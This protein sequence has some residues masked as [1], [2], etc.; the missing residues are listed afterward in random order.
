MAAL[1]LA[2]PLL[3]ALQSPWH[4]RLGDSPGDLLGQSLAALGDLD[5]DGLADF[6]AGLPGDNPAGPD[7]GAAKVLS[8]A[9]GHELL[10]LVGRARGERFGTSV[11]LAGD[12]DCD[13]LPD[14]FVG[15]PGASPGGLRGAGSAQL[16]SGRNAEVIYSFFGTEQDGELGSAVVSAGDMDGDGLPEIAIGSPGTRHG[17]G[18]VHVHSGADASILYTFHGDLPYDRFGA[19]LAGASDVDGDGVSDLAV[20]AHQPAGRAPGYARVLSGADASILYTFGGEEPG[21]GFG[22]AVALVGDLDGDGCAEVLVGAPFSDEMGAMAG[23]ARLFSGK[24]GEPLCAFLGDRPADCLGIAVA[25]VGDVDGDGVPD[26]AAGAHQ[27]RTP[28]PG[29]LRLW[30]GATRAELATL[31]G[32]APGHEFGVAAAGLGDLDGDGRG[33]IAVG[34]WADGTKG[35]WTG[36]VA[37][38]SSAALLAR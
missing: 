31:V 36:S 20:G 10:N 25:G 24:S 4:V 14:V 1:L 3:F 22:L 7:S 29:Y 12:L 2:G 13:G 18:T 33:D 5:G 28:A 35:V 26:L 27:P 30:S 34:A 19:A 37:V 11:A 17:T 32:A 15:A 23:S 9:A 38:F 16:F 21:D 8:G 6:V